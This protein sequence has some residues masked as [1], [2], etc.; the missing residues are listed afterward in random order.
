MQLFVLIYSL[1][2]VFCIDIFALQ[3]YK[4]PLLFHHH[5]LLFHPWYPPPPG[6]QIQF[7]LPLRVGS[8]K[9]L[10]ILNKGGKIVLLGIALGMQ[11]GK[12][13]KR[14]GTC[15]VV[16]PFVSSFTD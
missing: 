1:Y 16:M 5:L 4:L 9:F 15:I 11:H 14:R 6:L 12:W 2:V 3:F 8:V 10:T 13:N 7:L